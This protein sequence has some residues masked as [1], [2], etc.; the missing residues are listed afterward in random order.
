MSTILLFFDLMVPVTL[1]QRWI[2]TLS[3]AN[4]RH[5]AAMAL[6]S[7]GSWGSPDTDEYQTY[8]N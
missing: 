3:V 4:H 1:E 8:S 2:V 7:D 5:L 6:V